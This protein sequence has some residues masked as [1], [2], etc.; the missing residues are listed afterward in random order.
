M[1][2][3]VKT[4]KHTLLFEYS[5]QANE[6][7]VFKIFAQL[8]H[9][10][11]EPPGFAYVFPSSVE[12]IPCCWHQAMEV[13]VK[14]KVLPPGMQ[15]DHRTGFGTIMGIAKTSEYRPYAPEHEAVEQVVVPQTYF[16]KTM[17]NGKNNMVVLYG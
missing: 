4:I 7:F 8:G 1:D 12:G 3:L 14:C 5:F 11:K 10:I 6:K 16:V 17:R 9:R 13:R 2:V 15:H